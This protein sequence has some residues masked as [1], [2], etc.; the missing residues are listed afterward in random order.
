[1]TKVTVT[2]FLTAAG[3]RY[4][5]F[6]T[7]ARSLSVAGKPDSLTNW[8]ARMSSAPSR[9]ECYAAVVVNAR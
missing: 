8:M 7:V 3:E 5:S 4:E 6:Q 9:F 2:S 1:M